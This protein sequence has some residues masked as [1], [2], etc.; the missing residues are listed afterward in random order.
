M[1][2]WVISLSYLCMRLLFR[3]LS[4][5]ILVY[6]G[7]FYSLWKFSSQLSNCI[8]LCFDTSEFITIFFSNFLC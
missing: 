7:L 5:L 3:L 1:L 2:L 4:L 8:R 6:I